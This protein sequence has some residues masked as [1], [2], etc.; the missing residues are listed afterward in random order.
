MVVEVLD[1]VLDDVLDE[2]PAEVGVPGADATVEAAVD[3]ALGSEGSTTPA[4]D[5][6]GDVVPGEASSS[7]HP[8]TPIRQATPI[9]RTRRIAVASCSLAVRSIRSSLPRLAPLAHVIGT[10]RS[11]TDARRAVAADA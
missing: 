9:T 7:E 8:A 6:A 1:E 3:T 4:V 2:V 5:D 11:H 10:L